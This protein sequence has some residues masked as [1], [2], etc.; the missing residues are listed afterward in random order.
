MVIEVE[1]KD[2]LTELIAAGAV[3]V[4]VQEND[5]LDQGGLKFDEH[6][7]LST[8]ATRK[9]R[10]SPRNERPF[11]FYCRSGVRSYK[12]A[13]IAAEWSESSCYILQGGYPRFL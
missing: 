1:T 8:F 2:E 6:W 4:N 5:E 11:V 7:P 12:A 13:E 3:L 9:A 10:V